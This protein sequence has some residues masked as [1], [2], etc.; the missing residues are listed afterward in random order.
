MGFSLALLALAG[1]LA[2]GLAEVQAWLR[3]QELP[4]SSLLRAGEL[5]LKRGWY[6][7]A[8]PSL[9][10]LK[11]TEGLQ[12]KLETRLRLGGDWLLRMQEPGGRFHYW[13][14]PDRQAVSAPDD[15]N[16]LRQAGTAYAL[17]L[18]AE[19]LG[20]P[21]YLEA[22]ER[23][24]DH[25]RRFVQVLDGDRALFL[26]QGKAKL[27]GIALPMLTLLKRR[28]LRGDGVDD[29][30]LRGLARMILDLQQ[31]GGGGRFKSTHV[32]LGDPEYER[33]SGWD[34]QIYPG[35]AMLALAEMYRAFGDP[36][37]LQ[38][39]DRAVDYYGAANRWRAHAFLSWSIAAMTSL[40]QQTGASRYAHFGL[41]L[42][43]FLLTQQNLDLDD[44]I[45][46]SFHAF[47]SANTATYL[48]GLAEGLRLALQH[49][50]AERAARYRQ[51]LLLGL[52]WLGVL[53]IDDVDAT[54]ASDPRAR[55]GVRQSLEV[56]LLRIDNTQHSISAL[57]RS[58]QVL[59]GAA[60]RWVGGSSESPVAVPPPDAAVDDSSLSSM[61]GEA[62][63]ER[64]HVEVPQGER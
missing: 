35:E 50:D 30:L 28:S 1:G 24:L 51:H 40:H 46:G 57:V 48:E 12:H 29:A 38:A 17:A 58:L 64:L 54:Y 25:Q 3:T 31:R 5:E 7:L 42:S 41:Q 19:Q 14:R 32:Y 47:P 22:A 43:D 37:Y 56:P 36:S 2:L 6:R 27:G 62:L 15:D 61:P 4:A 55:G 59:F 23:A 26:F 8:P 10:G 60:P 53:Q 33:S 45:A 13:Y 21:R 18:A 11:V 39:V 52:R 44:Q 16:F 34:S 9:A 20:E 49:G 63:P